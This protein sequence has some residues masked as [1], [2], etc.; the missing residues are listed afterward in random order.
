MLHQIIIPTWTIYNILPILT[1]FG[2]LEKYFFTVTR[3]NSSFVI[4]NNLF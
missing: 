2:N 3:A 4:I 1:L